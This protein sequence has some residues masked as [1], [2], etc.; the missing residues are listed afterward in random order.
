MSVTCGRGGSYV[1][2]CRWGPSSRERRSLEVTVTWTQ[3]LR[4]NVPHHTLEHGDTGVSTARLSTSTGEQS[5]LQHGMLGGAGVRRVEKKTDYKA[6]GRRLWSR[7]EHVL[8]T[9]E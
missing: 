1:R 4:E 6:G 3:G 7:D 9:G 8:P 2:M 5:P